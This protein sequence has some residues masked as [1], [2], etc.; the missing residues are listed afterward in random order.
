MYYSGSFSLQ[1]LI[2]RYLFQANFPY[3]FS[4][5]ITMTKKIVKSNRKENIQSVFF[6]DSKIFIK[7]KFLR[8]IFSDIE[9][10]QRRGYDFKPKKD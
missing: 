1:I 4:A 2:E 8:F 6:A 10:Y 7:I 5:T 9:K 3:K